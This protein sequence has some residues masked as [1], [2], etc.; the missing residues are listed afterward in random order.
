LGAGQ[1]RYRLRGYRA[2]QDKEGK[3]IMNDELGIAEAIADL[4]NLD[5]RSERF[6][7]GFKYVWL[8]LYALFCVAVL[9]F[10][11]WAIW[12]VAH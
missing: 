1:P 3:D 11:V 8:T 7:R 5:K 10:F 6:Q 4:I 12:S 2:T 9:A